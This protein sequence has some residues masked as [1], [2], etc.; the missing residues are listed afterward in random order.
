LALFGFQPISQV[1]MNSDDNAATVSHR[2]AFR[3]V[4]KSFQ[5]KESVVVG[6]GRK[7]R[8]VS[9][10][11]PR[12]RC[13]PCIDVL[14]DTLPSAIRETAS[15]I[16]RGATVR[17]FT[18]DAHPGLVLLSGALSR[19]MQAKLAHSALIDWVDPP[20]RSNLS[21]DHDAAALSRLFERA[22]LDGES[23][24]LQLLPLRRWTTLGYQYDWSARTYDESQFVPMPRDLY[25][26]I[27]ELV[28][29]NNQA[30]GVADRPFASEAVI[31]NYYHADSTLCGHLDDAERFFDAPIVSISLGLDAVF[32]LGGRTKDETP[33][34][35][36]VRSGDVVLMGGESRFAHHGVPRVFGDSFQ[37]S[38]QDE[39]ALIQELSSGSTT[40]ALLMVAQRRWRRVLARMRTARININVRQVNDWANR[41]EKEE[42]Q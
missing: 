22:E 37:L 5:L 16:F 36:L 7:S 34:A 29:C 6:E 21:A 42:E 41:R 11:V 26:L 15:P 39:D 14:A 12:E 4:E 32:L 20:N 3:R 23:A 17:R 10:L 1:K 27:A 9:R 24:A 8:R 40:D 25:D 35:I 13:A 30:A 18:F 38:T 2:T 31:V 33:S 28:Q 19:A